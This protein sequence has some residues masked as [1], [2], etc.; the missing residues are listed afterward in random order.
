MSVRSVAQLVEG[1]STLLNEALMSQIASIVFRDNLGN[2]ACWVFGRWDEY[3]VYA[4]QGC[5]EAAIA[6]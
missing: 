5:T 4:D 1:E 6:P 3:E 2:E